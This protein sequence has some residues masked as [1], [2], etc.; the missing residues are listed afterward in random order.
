MKTS[1]ILQISAYYPPHLGGQE[2]VVQDLAGRLTSTGNE[3]DVVTSNLGAG[4]GA[5]VEN[6]VRVTRLRSSEFA[7]TPIIWGLF[8]W[9]IKNVRRETIIHLH[10]GQFFTPEIV[11]LASKIKRFK[12]IIHLHIDPVP[13][14]AMGRIL[15]L[16]KKLFLSREVRAA[17]III[18]LNEEHGRIL[19]R[20]YQ[21]ADKIVVM[22][23]GI[24]QDYFEIVRTPIYSET[25]KL[26]Y[27][28]RLSPQKNLPILL[29][30]LS[31]LK[32]D[33]TLDII[34]DGECRRELEQFTKDNKLWNVAFHGRLTR[35]EIAAYYA[36]RDA[37][38]LPSLYE[39]QPI[40]LLE[41][42][43]SR[44]PIIATKVIGIE[45][46]AKD[47]AIL[48]QPTVQGIAEGITCFRAMPSA[49]VE[50]L[51]DKAFNKA[52]THKWDEIIKSYT[53]L[54]KMIAEE[55]GHRVQKHS[56]SL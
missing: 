21:C 9:L 16:Y 12:Y 54:Y 15:P 51:V 23:N 20:D 44:I 13:S 31:T 38:I 33:V 29:K 19:A 14:S 34:G 37:L 47:A 22:S 40:V 30:A 43:A 39:A 52:Q 17:E 36:T 46:E 55:N 3:V 4:S 7:H 41:A 11:W 25:L 10:V 45:S 48:V 42:M 35:S 28:G 56:L 1:G 5:A 18:V 8:C 27:V 24:N 50:L 6:G 49:A 32:D 2:I 53:R 26:L